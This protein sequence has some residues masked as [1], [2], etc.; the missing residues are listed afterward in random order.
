VPGSFSFGERDDDPGA[1]TALIGDDLRATRRERGKRAVLASALGAG[2]DLVFAAALEGWATMK[3]AFGQTWRGFAKRPLLSAVIVL[4]FALAIGANAAVFSVLDAVLVRPLPYAQADRL[5]YVYESATL[6]GTPCPKCTVSLPDAEDLRGSP[7]VAGLA[8]FTPRS[9]TFVDG[10]SAAEFPGSRVTSGY[11]DVL[12]A[13]A[14]LG[15]T[16]IAADADPGTANAIAI[17]ER[18]WRSRFGADPHTVGRI[19]HTS[20]AAYTVVGVIPDTFA[21]PN[22]STFGRAG[23]DLWTCAKRG[24]SPRGS[25]YL[26]VVARLS[27]GVDIAAAQHDLGRIMQRLATRY[28]GD[29]SGRGVTV[30]G[31]RD[32]LLGDAR[33][34]LFVVLA[35]VI[36]LLAI[37]CANIANLLLAA[38]STRRHE[39]AV[40]AALGATRARIAAEF[41]A[42]SFVL[43]GLGALLGAGLA[44][45]AVRAFVALGPALPRVGEVRLDGAVVAYLVGITVAAAIAASVIPVVDAVRA[46]IAAGLRVGGRFAQTPGG[47]RRRTILTALE[48]ALALALVVVSSL[49][50]RTFVAISATDLGADT[51]HVFYAFPGPLSDARYPTPAAQTEFMRRLLARLSAMPAVESAGLAINAPLSV[52]NE[53]A[54]DFAIVGSRASGRSALQPTA[55]YNAL[56]PGVMAALRLPVKIGRAIGLADGASARR[57]AVVNETFARRYLGGASALGRQLKIGFADVGKPR[58]IVGV[59]GD[60][61]GSDLLAAPPPQVYV[62]LAQEPFQSYA[63]VVRLHTDDRAAL[64]EL[65]AVWPALDRLQ[66]PPRIVSA[67]GLLDTYAA[68]TRLVA[69]LLSALAALALAQALSGV[70]AIVS[71]SV[72]RRTRE[73]GLRMALGADGRAIVLQVVGHA[74][75]V[76]GAGVALGLGLAAGCASVIR[77]QLYGVGVLDPLTYLSVAALIVAAA[78]LAAVLPALRATRIQPAAA[79]RFE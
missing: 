2:A 5:V 72:A 51:A 6:G 26:H 10:D 34:K 62:P 23:A 43:A 29:D 79:L 1:L 75:A 40:R 76:A 74:V 46:D 66:A 12:G 42:E 54:L 20:T 48:V 73:F 35:A 41:L 67:A 59:V 8:A 53:L 27:P 15:R 14:R 31:M 22:P 63:A 11:F 38:S 68:P 7:A 69:L 58:E 64:A 9:A 16:F 77:A 70:Y 45:A 28:P 71:F 32:E 50:V 49:M 60:V 78:S 65:A 17:S 52:R 37:G 21:D 3:E 61:R 44:Y 18:L 57:V 25:H 33:P 30:V 4:T 55:N 39:T 19:V 36:G 47:E 56:T 24:E 13:Q